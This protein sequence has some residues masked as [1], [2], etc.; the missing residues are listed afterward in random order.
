MSDLGT[1][2]RSCSRVVHHR[3]LDDVA[4]EL[5]VVGRKPETDPSL[6]DVLLQ[7][8]RLLDLLEEG[9]V[10][11]YPKYDRLNSLRGST[12]LILGLTVVIDAYLAGA[13]HSE[14][15][16]PS[17]FATSGPSLQCRSLRPWV[18]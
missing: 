15:A 14:V 11:S 6:Q 7:L 10:I 3:G 9:G 18:T 16:A 4:A 8:Q 17:W 1:V 5:G 2:V 13:T 12:Q